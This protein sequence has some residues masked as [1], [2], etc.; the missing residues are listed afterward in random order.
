MSDAPVELKINIVAK[1]DALESEL[2][3]L[4]GVL[5]AQRALVENIGM[6]HRALSTSIQN[7]ILSFGAIRERMET[8]QSALRDLASTQSS[9]MDKV[10]DLQKEKFSDFQTLCA[11]R[12]ESTQSKITMLGESFSKQLNSLKDAMA[13]ADI[14]S[15]AK[16]AEIES[17]INT[18]M[19]GLILAL[20]TYLIKLLYPQLG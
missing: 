16:I 14:E 3:E 9:G 6:D 17:K 18:S 2:A 10:T 13:A 20:L 12:V 5:S 8:V 11:A 19:Y 15:K 1:I 4:R 7:T